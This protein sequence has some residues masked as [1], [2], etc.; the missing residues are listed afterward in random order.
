MLLAKNE[1][2]YQNLVRL[3]SLGYLEGFYYRPRIDREL[4]EQ[5]SDGL[6]ALSA[7]LKGSVAWNLMQE[8][9]AEAREQAGM[10]SEIFGKGTSIS[11][12]R[13]TGW[14]SRRR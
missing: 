13:T 2:G 6:I 1:K 10:L 9:D 4:L 11:R 8:R 7:C 3:V 14:R 12:F 5:Y